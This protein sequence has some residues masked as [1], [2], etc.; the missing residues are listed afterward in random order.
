MYANNLFK[1]AN[2]SVTQWSIGAHCFT[3][4]NFR[5][6]LQIKSFTFVGLIRTC[7]VKKKKLNR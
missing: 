6:A 2:Q 4:V 5:L 1:Q 7:W 3:S